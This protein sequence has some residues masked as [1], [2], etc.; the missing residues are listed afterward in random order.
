MEID[1]FARSTSYAAQMLLARLFHVLHE[2]NVLTEAE[3][4]QVIKD[5]EMALAHHHTETANAARGNLLALRDL[6]KQPPA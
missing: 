1:I 4:E 6:W 5:A 3:V 2:K